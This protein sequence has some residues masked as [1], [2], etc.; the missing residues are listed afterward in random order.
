[1]AN[2]CLFPL[3]PKHLIDAF[4]INIGDTFMALTNGLYRSCL[5]RVLVNDK[6]NRKSLAF[7]IKPKSDKI[8]SP[9]EELLVDMKIK[10]IILDFTWA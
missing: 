10:G 8:V 9:P 2:A 3:D 1:M 4:V 5:H 7:F 6:K